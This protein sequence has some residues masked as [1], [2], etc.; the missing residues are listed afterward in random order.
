MANLI[1]MDGSQLPKSGEILD[2]GGR[3]TEDTALVTELEKMKSDENVKAA[4][5]G[6]STCFQAYGVFRKHLQMLQDYSDE[7]KTELTRQIMLAQHNVSVQL[8]ELGKDLQTVIGPMF[9]R[10]HNEAVDQHRKKQRVYDNADRKVRGLPIYAGFIKPDLVLGRGEI[11]FMSVKY[12]EQIEQVAQE[13]TT[14]FLAENVR[15]CYLGYPSDAQM[16]SMPLSVKGMHIPPFNWADFMSSADSPTRN[17]KYAD[18]LIC[19]SFDDAVSKDTV[20]QDMHNFKRH[21]LEKNGMSVIFLSAGAPTSV[22]TVAPWTDVSLSVDTVVSDAVI[23]SPTPLSKLVVWN[24]EAATKVA[25]IPLRA[26]PDSEKV[27]FS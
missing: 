9:I 18:V 6:M 26:I 15:A 3:P 5:Y 17:L 13:L 11:A 1:S 10:L 21:W 8:D 24:G 14:R 27:V 7:A 23:P 12:P 4:A 2:R 20:I 22:P 25:D 16:E 19:T